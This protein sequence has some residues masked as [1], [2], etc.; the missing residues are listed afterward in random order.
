MYVLKKI[1]ICQLHHLSNAWNLD[2]S[3]RRT[4]R[5]SLATLSPFRLYSGEF[6]PCVAEIQFSNVKRGT[7][8]DLPES[9]RENYS[10]AYSCVEICL[11][12]WKVEVKPILPFGEAHRVLDVGKWFH[13]LREKCV[14]STS[15]NFASQPRSRM[16]PWISNPSGWR[17]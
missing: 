6:Q 13:F 5:Q 9:S 2:T 14:I 15:Y 11:F 10:R 3:W 12:W 7:K 4:H 17:S 1:V 8:D 16:N